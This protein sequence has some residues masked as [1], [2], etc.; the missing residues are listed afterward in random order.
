MP[1]RPRWLP[2]TAAPVLIGVSL[3]LSPGAAPR[4][5]GTLEEVPFDRKLVAG[6]GEAPERFG[7]ALALSGDV[8]VVAAPSATVDGKPFAGAGRVFARDPGSGEWTERKR[9][10][11]QDGVAFDQL[12][13][14]A[15]AVDGDTV[16]LGASRA[17]VGNVLQQG[18]VYVFERNAG[19]PDN[20]GQSAKLTDETV[21]SVGNFGTGIAIEGDLL[22]VGAGRAGGNGQV[23][24][25]ERDRDGPGTWGKVAAIPDS[26]VGDGG[27][28][29]EFFGGAVALDGDL[30]LVGAGSADVSFF[31]E[32]DGAAYIFRRHPVER[33]RWDFVTR[34]TAPEAALCGG[35]RTLAE[36]SLD[37]L[38]V[39]LE[40]QR[41]AQQ[42]DSRTDR[43]AFGGRVAIEDDTV[44][45]AAANAEGASGLPV[46]AVYVFRRDPGG[47]DRW[48]LVTK[49]TGSD[50]LASTSPGF[51]GGLAL[52][53]DTLLVGALG[54][55][56]GAKADQGAAYRFERGAGG[57]DAWGE[58]AKL[59]AGD[60]LSRE[61]FGIAVALDGVDGVIGARGYELGQGA[62]YLAGER[63]VPGPAF[64][65]TG[66]LVDG[67]VVEGPGGVVLGAV[68]GAIA[69]PLPVWIVEVPAPDEPLIAGATSRGGF[70]NIGGERRAAAADGAPFGLALPVP[71]GADTAHLAAAVLARADEVLDV[72]EGGELWIPL[73]GVYDAA[74]NRFS[75][76]L[77][78]L[79]LEGST[80][81]LIEHPDLG[82]SAPP[83]AAA[84]REPGP[85]FEITCHGFPSPE[86]CG[87][88]QEEQ[89]G[90][91]LAEAH[92]RF[93]E[94]GYVNPALRNELV[95]L[96]TPGSFSAIGSLT[97]VGNQIRP[98]DIKACEDINGEFFP[99]RYVFFGRKIEFCYAEGVTS[100]TDIQATVAHELFHAFQV[101]F[102]GLNASLSS[103]REYKW[104]IEGTA[105][106]AQNSSTRMARDPLRLPHAVDRGLT[107][108]Q[109]ASDPYK[110][111][112][113]WVY[114]GQ[115]RSLGL[116]YLRPLFERGGTTQAAADFLAEVHQTTLGAEYWAWVRNQA[117]EKANLL[118]QAL[119][120]PCRLEFPRDNLLIGTVPVLAHGQGDLPPAVKGTLE[121][122]TA[123]VVRIV[124]ARDLGPTIITAAEQAGL[125]YKVY[126]NGTKPCGP[127][128]EDG[129]RQFEELS[130]TDTVYVVLANTEHKAGSRIP[131]EVQVKPAPP[132]P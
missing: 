113:F 130:I 121:R 112:D 18:A 75:L 111:Q 84:A 7:S 59:V 56:V 14:S 51:G 88:D 66:L 37:T 25:F 12:G 32:D 6:T 19:G 102:D 82:P 26:A 89:Y 54:A 109:P 110:A 62:V 96:D 76:A 64:A 118:D 9:L 71:A 95:L 45:V 73:T 41:C 53:G 98:K 35:G 100:D 43:D 69:E 11:A 125:K 80:V 30:L 17:K 117:F 68:A 63:P 108:I 72:P 23:T 90:F 34:L 20:W 105:T 61:D 79:T 128:I 16:L 60:G 103:P 120:D 78:T 129:E 126:L 94:S 92:A 39:R 22:A 50:I 42:P 107:S 81:V 97:Y 119:A 99:R 116:D 101:G 31:G 74:G 21:G 47:A 33:D 77:D 132:P 86:L 83:P 49:L 55:E 36:V 3:C 29:L 8:L 52:A 127:E 10:V 4:A 122:L 46:G 106:A 87:A 40:V 114:F 28:P 13:G 15:V 123:Q 5:Q 70:Y 2:T 85:S 124:F 38:E 131:Y 57:P 44:V 91:D 24:I 104:V 1:P 58:V 93:T 67:G 48:D 115:E 27:S 65:A